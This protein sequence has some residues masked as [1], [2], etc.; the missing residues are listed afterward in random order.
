MACITSLGDLSMLSGENRFEGSKSRCERSGLEGRV[1]A[2]YIK[3]VIVGVIRN[4]FR[5]NFESK[6]D[7]IY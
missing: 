4:S 5:V 2:A 1:M 6:I 7:K 3:V